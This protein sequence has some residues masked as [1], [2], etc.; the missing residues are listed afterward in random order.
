MKEYQIL[1]EDGVVIGRYSS[2]IDRDEA[3]LQHMRR[4]STR[5]VELEI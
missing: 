4:R 1:D 3:Y 2:R 5:E